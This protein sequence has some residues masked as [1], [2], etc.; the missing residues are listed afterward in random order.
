MSLIVFFESIGCHVTMFKE[1]EGWNWNLTCFN[2]CSRRDSKFWNLFVKQ[3]NAIFVFLLKKEK[4]GGEEEMDCYVYEAYQAEE[5]G[6]SRWFSGFAN[7]QKKGFSSV[8]ASI[9]L[10]FFKFTIC[11]GYGGIFCIVYSEFSEIGGM[12]FRR[13]FDFL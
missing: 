6:L 2:H 10:A 5:K 3:R 1:Y 8:Y 4:N 11:S 12:S 9:S 7:R 13:F